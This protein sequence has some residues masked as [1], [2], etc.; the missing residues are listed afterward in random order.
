MIY[1]S[2]NVTVCTGLMLIY[3]WW[4]NFETVKTH[5]NIRNYIS[6]NKHPEFLAWPRL[7][8]SGYSQQ[9]ENSQHL[10]HIFAHNWHLGVSWLGNRP[11]RLRN[12][13]MVLWACWPALRLWLSVCHSLQPAAPL[14]MT[15]TLCLL[16]ISVPHL[17]GLVYRDKTKHYIDH[18]SGCI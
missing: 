7:S 15:C 16:N 10:T 9:N 1:F 6:T 14:T 5:E 8:I 12:R 4:H 13:L 2:I 11:L 3:S 18:G 17:I